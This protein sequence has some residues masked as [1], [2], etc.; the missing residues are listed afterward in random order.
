MKLAAWMSL[1]LVMSL[2]LF[3]RAVESAK[4]IQSLKSARS[5]QKK[6]DTVQD[7][8]V[9][10]SIWAVVITT[11]FLIGFTSLLWIMEHPIE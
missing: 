9:R 5:V 10:V 1:M 3:T 11:I 7:H 6:T 2:F 4:S 8:Q